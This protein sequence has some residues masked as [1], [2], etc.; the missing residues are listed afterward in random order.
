MT[1]ARAR[2]WLGITGVG[3][4][5]V[6]AAA[7]LA[8]GILPRLASTDPGQPVA[9]AALRVVAV[10]LGVAL[11]LVPLDVLGGRVVARAR[12]PFA[13]WAG[14]LARAVAVQAVAWW[15]AAVVLLAAARAGGP[16]AVVAA[17]LALQGA[18]LALRGPLARLV[19]A[20]DD[21]PLAAPIADAVRAAG[22]AA[23][24]VRVVGSA[25][26]GFVGGWVGLVRPRLW[27]PAHWARL[28]FQALVAQLVRRRAARDTGLHARGLALALGWNTAGLA[29]ALQ[30]PRADATHAAG[31]LTL[32]AWTTLWS[33]L[34]LLL[35]P[36][37]SRHAVY[38]LDVAAAQVAGREAV[39]CAAERLDAWQDDE[40]TRP[41]GVEAVFH[42]VPAR[43]ARMA[44]LAAG[45][46]PGAGQLAAHQAARHAL[47]AAWALLSP[48]SRVVHCN[49]GRPA[50]WVVWPGD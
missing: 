12:P 45:A 2:L 24:T 17:G 9:A 18:L 26:E 43:G 11:L 1:Y 23:D 22:L 16:W 21:R 28:P 4:V 35:L 50:L 49:V 15:V 10:L 27:V 32:V 6:L 34:G 29:L 14:R 25:D 42:P 48:L 31:L 46:A 8:F 20:V 47:W 30:L 40:R 38:A 44:A 41:A 33:F 39:G 37:P 3:T 13:T 36:T 7:A 19:A 5:V